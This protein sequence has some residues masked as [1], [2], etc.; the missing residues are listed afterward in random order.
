MQH[1][2]GAIAKPFRASFRGGFGVSI[3]RSNKRRCRGAAPCVGADSALAAFSP[4]PFVK[5]SIASAWPHELSARADTAVREKFYSRITCV[6]LLTSV[7]DL[8]VQ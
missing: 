6:Q 3:Q 2:G 7:D 5:D 4:S 8:S 1:D